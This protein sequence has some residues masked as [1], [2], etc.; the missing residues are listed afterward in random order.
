M[1]KKNRLN[2]MYFVLLF[3]SLDLMTNSLR[4]FEYLGLIL[5]K[6]MAFNIELL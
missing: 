3:F 4:K 6:Y 2:L 1:V 5:L